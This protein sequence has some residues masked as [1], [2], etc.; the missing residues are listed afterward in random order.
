MK[1]MRKLSTNER[2]DKHMHTFVNLLETLVYNLLYGGCQFRR[3][4]HQ[5]RQLDAGILKILLPFHGKQ[6]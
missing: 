4:K 6:Q 5:T 3:R 2:E 1:V